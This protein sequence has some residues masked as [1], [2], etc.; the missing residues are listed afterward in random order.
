MAANAR[1]GASAGRAVCSTGR[2]EL[3]VRPV[4]CGEDAGDVRDGRTDRLTS[5]AE[6]KTVSTRDRLVNIIV[7]LACLET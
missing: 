7:V 1:T 2:T 3:Y 5:A 4:W 6:K